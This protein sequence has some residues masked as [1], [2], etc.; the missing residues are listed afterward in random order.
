MSVVS[1]LCHCSFVLF[2]GHSWFIL[3]YI[4][5]LY[6]VYLWV[7]F[8][9]FQLFLF[10]S[11][12]MWWWRA[13]V[14]KPQVRLVTPFAPL[15]GFDPGVL[16]WG[17]HLGLGFEVHLLDHAAMAV[18]LLCRLFHIKKKKKNLCFMSL[19]FRFYMVCRQYHG[20]II[21]GHFGFERLILLLR[22]GE[23][24]VWSFSPWI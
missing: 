12:F 9:S 19:I 20:L 14:P 4:V 10:L 7:L 2:L 13:L 15:L 8:L 22:V 16:V 18:G 6:F 17:N 24:I 21:R 23:S 1:P 11:S 5:H 3:S